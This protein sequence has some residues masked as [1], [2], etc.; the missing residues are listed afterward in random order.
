M[1]DLAPSEDFAQRQSWSQMNAPWGHPY[2]IVHNC[3]RTGLRLRLEIFL[4][5]TDYLLTEGS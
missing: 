2:K 1:K 5:K 3:D 4:Q